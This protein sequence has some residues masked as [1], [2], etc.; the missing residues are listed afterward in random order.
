MPTLQT[1][2]DAH[3]IRE[4][5]ACFA[6]ILDSKRW[7]ALEDV[8]AADL[9]FNYGEGEQQG[10]DALR[11]QVRRYL[12]ACGNTQHLLGSISIDVDGDRAVSRSYVQARH[13]GFGDRAN[14]FFDANGEYIDQWTRCP[15]GWRISRRDAKWQMHMGTPSVLGKTAD[16]LR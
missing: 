1:L 15:Q 12:D 8:F 7:D 13:Q 9:N 3:A 10:V 6:R 4:T 5:L 16:R 14:L 11:A 2:L